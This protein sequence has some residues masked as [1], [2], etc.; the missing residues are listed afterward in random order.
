[1]GPN[2]GL[3]ANLRVTVLDGATSLR[4]SYT[5]RRGKN[6]KIEGIPLP[7]INSLGFFGLQ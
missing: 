6:K 2:V 1:M 7:K 5:S 3:G 4:L